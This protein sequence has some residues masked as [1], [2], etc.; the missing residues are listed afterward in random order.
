MVLLTVISC[1][2]E[3]VPEGADVVSKEY[4]VISLADSRDIKVMEERDTKT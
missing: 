4:T 3:K 1:E 2:G